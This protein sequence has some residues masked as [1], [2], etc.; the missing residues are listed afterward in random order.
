MQ[1]KIAL[2]TDVI[3]FLLVLFTLNRFGFFPEFPLPI[4]VVLS[5]LLG[6]IGDVYRFFKVEE[7]KGCQRLCRK[8]TKRTECTKLAIE[9]CLKCLKLK[10]TNNEY[11]TR[12][13]ECRNNLFS[14][15]IH[16]SLFDIGYL[17][18]DSQDFF[19]AHFRHFSSL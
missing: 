4:Q 5:F 17:S 18:D 15:I 1:Y 10:G 9:K 16:H 11:S 2:S 6:N 12:N 19:L 13:I 8:T 7:E 3:S 14:F